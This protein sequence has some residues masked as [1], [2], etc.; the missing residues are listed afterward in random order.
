[1]TMQHIHMNMHVCTHIKY[2]H[3]LTQAFKSH[4]YILHCFDN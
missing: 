2:V 3:T 4:M 1:M